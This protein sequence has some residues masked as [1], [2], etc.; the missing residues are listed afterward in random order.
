MITHQITKKIEN[1]K[2]RVWFKKEPHLVGDVVIQFKSW[3]LTTLFT[4]KADFLTNTSFFYV[5]V[6]KWTWS[7]TGYFYFIFRGE[8]IKEGFFYKKNKTESLI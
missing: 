2:R 8:E 7:F 1:G 6:P 3:G 4:L 5:D